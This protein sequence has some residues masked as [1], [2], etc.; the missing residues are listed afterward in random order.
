MKPY[1]EKTISENVRV[2]KFDASVPETALEWHRDRLDRVVEVI[3]GNGWMFQRDNQIP[4]MINP[5]D[6]IKIEALEWHRIIKG[7]EDLVLKITE[8]KKKKLSKKQKKIAQA[9]PPPDE[10]TGADFKALQARKDKKEVEEVDADILTTYEE[11]EDIFETIGSIINEKKKRKKRKKKAP[12]KDRKNPKQ[13]SAPQGSERDKGL[14]AAAA[15]YA[16]GDVKKAARIRDRMEKKARKEPGFKNKP[17]KDTGKYTKESTIISESSELRSLIEDIV[18]EVK[19][20]ALLEE[21]EK[22]ID[23]KRKKKK[24]KKSK[25]AGKLSAAVKKSLDKKA[26]KRCLTRGSVYSEFRKGLA[27]YLSSGSRKGM[28]AH[29]WAHA[30]VNSANPS[31]SWATVKKRKKCPSKKKKKK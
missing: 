17:R 11:S 24:K 20:D 16:A 27:A 28:S 18:E 14:D 8:E 19:L 31:K 21:V 6:E 25:S 12:S 30:R 7:K 4:F 29:Q 3:H 26:D 5:G 15:A 23:E 2:R 13:Y 10:I 9:A 1:S 22:R